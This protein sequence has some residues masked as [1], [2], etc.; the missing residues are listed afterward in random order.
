MLSRYEEALSNVRDSHDRFSFRGS[1]VEKCSLI[2]RPIVNEYLELLVHFMEMSGHKII[3]K[4]KNSGSKSVA[5][6]IFH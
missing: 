4:R 1:M 6:L 3:R 2:E 5:M